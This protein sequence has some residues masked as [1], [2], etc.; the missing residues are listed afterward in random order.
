MA[1]SDSLVWNVEDMKR[2]NY[3]PV[4][5]VAIARSGELR[6]GEDAVE[7]LAL[8]AAPVLANVA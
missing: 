1:G 8:L 4:F 3:L 6:A 7:L 5:F 2:L